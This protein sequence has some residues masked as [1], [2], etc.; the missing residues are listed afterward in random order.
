MFKLSPFCNILLFFWSGLGLIVTDRIPVQTLCGHLMIRMYTHHSK[1]IFQNSAFWT[2]VNI[3]FFQFSVLRIHCTAYCIFP[4]HYP[5]FM[6]Y[7]HF[8]LKM[9]YKVTWT[10]VQWSFSDFC[11]PVSFWASLNY[12]H[13]GSWSSLEP[14]CFNKIWHKSLQGERN[15]EFSKLSATSFSRADD[16]N[17]W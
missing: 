7:P 9:C 10:K 2:H 4:C 15:F 13:F 1:L 11:C 3:I 16:D 5:I 14:G 12:S 6:L 8:I 17:Y